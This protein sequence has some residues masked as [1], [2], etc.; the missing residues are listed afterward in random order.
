M[1]HGDPILPGQSAKEYPA[2]SG[3]STSFFLICPLMEPLNGRQE[4][5]NISLLQLAPNDLFMPG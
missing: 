4:V 3:T 1:K 5:L 2:N